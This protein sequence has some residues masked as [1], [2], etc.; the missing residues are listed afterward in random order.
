MGLRMVILICLKWW[1]ISELLSVVRVYFMKG[2]RKIREMVVQEMEQYVLMQG[3]R[4]LIVLLVMFMRMKVYMVLRK[5]K[6]F[7]VDWFYCCWRGGVEVFLFVVFFDKLIF[8]GLCVGM[9][10][11]FIFLELLGL[12]ILMWFGLVVDMVMGDWWVDDVV[13]L[14]CNFNYG[15]GRFFIYLMD[16]ILVLL[17][18][19][20]VILIILYF[21]IFYERKEVLKQRWF[22]CGGRGKIRVL[23]GLWVVYFFFML[24]LGKMCLFCIGGIFYVCF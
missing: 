4:V 19:V 8:L 13:E 9:M 7:V 3:R 14:G 11:L 2:D 10:D 12:L 21:R 18:I 17:D 6:M 1:W 15:Y 5:W 22:E 16:L 20:I 23:C 24:V